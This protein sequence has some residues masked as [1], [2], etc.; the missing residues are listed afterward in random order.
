MY[1][2]SLKLIYNIGN[3]KTEYTNSILNYFMYCL[4]DGYFNIIT[5][6]SN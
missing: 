1:I 2:C 4:I 5:P 3:F 6:I